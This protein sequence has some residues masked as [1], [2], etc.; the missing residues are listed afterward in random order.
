[1]VGGGFGEL[2]MNS[3][4]E[5]SSNISANVRQPEEDTDCFGIDGEESV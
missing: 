2:E 1:M 5:S 3:F 4:H